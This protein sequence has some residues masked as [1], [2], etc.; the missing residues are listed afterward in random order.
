MTETSLIERVS[1]E[2][3]PIIELLRQ[4]VEMES[5]S[6]SKELVDRLGVFVAEHLRDNGL[7]PQVVARETVGDIIW[8]DEARADDK[9]YK[10]SI[11]GVGGGTDYSRNTI[12]TLMKPMV[13]ELTESLVAS[14]F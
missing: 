9:K 6:H 13:E 2:I 10:A 8:A 5:P 7:D 3:D 4:L 12:S 1:S 14:D 11:D